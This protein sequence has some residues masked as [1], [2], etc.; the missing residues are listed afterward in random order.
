M[1]EITAYSPTVALDGDVDCEFVVGL[2]FEFGG[3]RAG[4][5]I[6]G[7]AFC[8]SF[9]VNVVLATRLA[10]RTR[11]RRRGTVWTSGTESVWT[12]RRF[13]G[14]MLSHGVET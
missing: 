4:D 9:K 1:D 11:C 8:A 13:R 14:R 10:C 5:G 12:D 2:E 6:G 7:E 3:G